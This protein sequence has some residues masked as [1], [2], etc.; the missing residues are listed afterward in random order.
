MI[1][2]LTIKLFTYNLIRTAFLYAPNFQ[3]QLLFAWGTIILMMK[4]RFMLNT[5]MH[6]W[7]PQPEGLYDSVCVVKSMVII[8][9]LY[10]SLIPEKPPD[11]E[12]D[13]V[14]FIPVEVV[15]FKTGIGHP[16]VMN[17]YSNVILLF[18]FI[19]W[20]GLVPY[21]GIKMMQTVLDSGSGPSG[22]TTRAAQLPPLLDIKFRPN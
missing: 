21:D 20:S 9:K 13:S 3:Q 12:I 5:H 6:Y 7:N 17:V 22:S 14:F 8:Y 2:F 11:G 19:V 15:S 4:N 10:M 18:P 16:M 1:L